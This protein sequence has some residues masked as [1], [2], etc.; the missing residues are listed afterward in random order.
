MP[1]DSCLRPRSG[2][3]QATRETGR[4]ARGPVVSYLP[5]PR[6]ASANSGAYTA[7]QRNGAEL[8]AS[9]GPDLPS[10][11]KESLE[12]RRPAPAAAAAAAFT[13]LAAAASAWR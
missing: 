11:A 7:V 6:L 5:R 3:Q 4:K 2:P 10:M 12:P 9:P 8:L 13:Q 1:G